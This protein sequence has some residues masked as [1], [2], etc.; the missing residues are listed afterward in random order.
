MIVYDKIMSCANVFWQ[1]DII[2][3]VSCVLCIGERPSVEDSSL[4]IACI[5][6]YEFIPRLSALRFI[7]FIIVDVTLQSLLTDL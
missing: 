4:I 5:L 1:Q 6:T 3:T 2:F 7:L